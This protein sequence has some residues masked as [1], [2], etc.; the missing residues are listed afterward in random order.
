MHVESFARDVTFIPGR[1]NFD[2]QTTAGAIFYGNL[3]S[4]E[5]VGKLAPLRWH[6]PESFGSVAE[7]AFF[8]NLRANGRMRANHDALAALNA[9][10]SFPNGHFK[11]D[12][13]LLPLGRAYTESAVNRKRAHGQ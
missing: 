6:V 11:S 9:Q 4:V 8:I 12:V 10:V 13:S 7:S 5:L 1:T 2:T 3:D